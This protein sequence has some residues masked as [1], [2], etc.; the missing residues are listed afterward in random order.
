MIGDTM[1]SLKED[2]TPTYVI[3]YDLNDQVSQISYCELNT[4]VPETLSSEEESRLGI[5]TILC[6]R[7]NVS[8][9]YFG[10]EAEKV[11]A[12]GEGTLVGKL[13]SFARSGAKI[14][15]EGEAYDC[16][17]LLVLFIRRSLNQLAMIASPEQVEALIFTVDT[18]EGKTIDV[19]S[20]VASALSIPK[21]KIFFQTY[22]ESSYYY[23]LHQPKELWEHEVA[24]FDYS[25]QFMQ[26]YIMWQNARTQPIVAF[27]DRT[28]FTELKTPSLMLTDNPTDESKDY[29]DEYVLNTIHKH[30]NSRMVG[31][32][33][34]IG[35]GF[36]ESWC[37]KTLSYLCMGKRVFQGKNLYSK[38]ACYC[39]KDRLK[40]SE[41]NKQYVF[42]GADKLKFNLGLQMRK[43][44]EE[45][46][47]ALFDAGVNWYDSDKEFDCILEEGSYV[48]FIVTPLD[49]KDKEKITVELAGLPTRPKRATRLN[50]KVKMASETLIQIRI[51]D[52]GFGEMYPLS[53]KVWSK[54][55]E[56]V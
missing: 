48:N 16:V 40:P 30:I 24:I 43:G 51:M 49:G 31:T 50:I 5:P 25:G 23:I 11:A 46:Y 41:L 26:S 12:H 22:E 13:L 47:F 17:D 54:D 56:M 37:K 45:E 35:D 42:L 14:E 55:V 20:K 33:F 28:D 4:D 9:W 39:A 10:R 36:D 44:R 21:E 34:L 6:K 53:G 15:L 27:V 2:R 19:L 52:L 32:V 29:L 18:L 38:G 7:K 8:Q 1:I 3:G